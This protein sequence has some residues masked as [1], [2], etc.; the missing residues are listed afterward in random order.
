MPEEVQVIDAAAPVIHPAPAEATGGEVTQKVV[1]PR[2][3]L[4]FVVN[5]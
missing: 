1:D 2:E 4:T 5:S 3:R